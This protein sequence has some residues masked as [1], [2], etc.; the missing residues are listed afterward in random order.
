MKITTMRFAGWVVLGCFG[1]CTTTATISRTDSPDNEAEIL[2]SDEHAL[3]VR[4]S[5]GRT[6]RLERER[7]ADID[8]PGNVNMLVGAGL[9]GI[10]ALIMSAAD[11]SERGGLLTPLG[12]AYGLPGL[13][14]FAHGTYAYVS[15]VSA[16]HAFTSAQTVEVPVPREHLEQS[17]PPQPVEG[18]SLVKRR[19]HQRW[20]D[21][22]ATRV[23]A[24]PSPPGPPFASPTTAATPAPDSTEQHPPPGDPTESTVR[25]AQP[26]PAQPEAP[27][28][29]P[30]SM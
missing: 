12:L 29:A 9:L 30:P 13:G 17:G 7:V 14:L 2:R 24:A 19:P 10:L 6:Y 27:V 11:R 1:G 3:Y 23:G 25:T 21:P 8:H 22:S 4:G 18:S 20:D 16:A 26:P 5:N 28:D 15:S